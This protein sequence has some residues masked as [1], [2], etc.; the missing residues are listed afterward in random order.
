MDTNMMTNVHND[1]NMG[2]KTKTKTNEFTIRSTKLALCKS[3]VQSAFVKLDLRKRI[4]KWTWKRTRTRTLA[5]TWIRTPKQNSNEH[6]NQHRHEGDNA[7]ERSNT[8]E[9]KKKWG[10]KQTRTRPRKPTQARNMHT[11]KNA[12]PIRLEK[13]SS[14]PTLSAWVLC[15]DSRNVICVS[16]VYLIRWLKHIS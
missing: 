15:S 6:T 3:Y 16:T 9:T 4:R 14:D 7:H 13:S 10:G 8:H 11:N 5:W 12:F 1:T 2:T